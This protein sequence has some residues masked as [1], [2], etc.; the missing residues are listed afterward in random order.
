MQIEASGRTDEIPF[1]SLIA[2]YSLNSLFDI[3]QRDPPVFAHLPSPIFP[4]SSPYREFAG[5]SFLAALTKKLRIV[6]SQFQRHLPMYPYRLPTFIQITREDPFVFACALDFFSN[7]FLLPTRLLRA[8]PPIEVDSEIIDKL[9]L[10]AKEALTT[11]LTNI[12]NIDNLIASLPS[13]SS[14]SAPSVSAV[15]KQTT[16][17][18]RHLR[19]GCKQ[20]VHNAR[21]F[22]VN[23]KPPPSDPCIS[24]FRTALFDTRSFP[25]LILNSLELDDKEIKENTITAITNILSH[26][27][28]I[29]VGLR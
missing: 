7:A 5:F 11:I 14:P 4:S 20:F 28:W 10:F 19:N 29:R 17:S 24:S 22:L 15:D 26:Y 8:K 2:N 27:P 13:D 16:D 25:D 6:F 9:I 3:I 12:S 21:V 18:L 1:D 23:V